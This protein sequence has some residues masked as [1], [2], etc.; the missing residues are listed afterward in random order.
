[1]MRMRFGPDDESAFFAARDQLID[2]FERWLVEGGRSPDLAADGPLVPDF[3]WSY[4]DGDLGWWTV[5]HLERLLLELYPR[6]VAAEPDLI[7]TTIPSVSAFLEF[8][9]DQGLLSPASDPLSRLDEALAGLSDPFREAMVDRSGWG[10]AKSLFGAMTDEGVDTSDAE[11]MRSWVDRFNAGTVEERDEVVGPPMARMMEAAQPRRRLRPVALAPEDRLERAARSAPAMVRLAGFVDYV[12]TPRPLTDRGNLKLAD[13]RHL[14]EALDTGDRI[15]EAIGERTFKTT[16]STELVTLDLT[17]RWARA[18]GL[19]KVRKGKV[20]A[21]KAGSNVD[22]DPLGSCYRALLGLLEVGVLTHHYGDD[23]YGFGW[24]ATDVD[25]QVTEWLLGWYEHGQQDI[26]DLAEETWEW[27]QELFDLSG[28]EQRKLDMHRSFVEHGV[29][30]ILDRL[31]ELGIVDACDVTEV[32]STVGVD[33]IGGTVQLTELGTWAVNRMAAPFVDAPVAG[34]H[35]GDDAATLLKRCADLPDDVARAELE[36]WIAAR[37]TRAGAMDLAAALRTIDPVAVGLGFNAL[38]RLGERATDA[39]RSLEDDP[40][41]APYVTVWRV[42]AMD[43]DPSEVVTRDPAEQVALLDAVLDLRGPHPLA[44]WLPLMLGVRS[45]MGR[46]EVVEAV[47]E[48][49]RPRTEQ[50]EEVL[51]AI[52]ATHPDKA[53]AKSARR[54]LF[55]L[56]SGAG[57]SPGRG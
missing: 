35:V 11:A 24:Y 37:D 8:L 4:L 39:V 40:R 14:V 6:K 50:A 33:R 47:G 20:S 56:R 9:D 25:A 27:L 41:L 55:K 10:L 13:A 52:A 18:A 21:T 3:K 26:E 7:E 49:W 36:A 34:T 19:V 38:L 45:D 48:L 15:D 1:M 46:D 23:N 12:A 22:A 2:R 51:G 44:M 43:I 17:F 53:V 57:P 29:R 5:G 42:D 30:R 31:A 54:A 32:E 28:I 16:S